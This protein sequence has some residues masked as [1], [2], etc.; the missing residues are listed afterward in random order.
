MSALKEEWASLLKLR[1]SGFT[2]E[3]KK[4]EIRSRIFNNFHSLRQENS[5]EVPEI[6]HIAIKPDYLSIRQQFLSTISSVERVK[7]PEIPKKFEFGLRNITPPPTHHKKNRIDLTSEEIWN[8]PDTPFTKNTSEIVPDKYE[9]NSI[10]ESNS[11]SR[12][13]SFQRKL[14]DI[15]SDISPITRYLANITLEEEQKYLKEAKKHDNSIFSYFHLVHCEKKN[16]SLERLEWEDMKLICNGLIFKSEILTRQLPQLSMEKATSI[17]TENPADG[18]S[19]CLSEP[20]MLLDTSIMKPSN[21][22][23]S[24]TTSPL[25]QATDDNSMLENDLLEMMDSIKNPQDS[26]DIEKKLKVLLEHTNKK[27]QNNKEISSNMHIRVLYQFLLEY[28][29]NNEDAKSIVKVPSVKR[30]A[31]TRPSQ[32]KTITPLRH[33]EVIKAA[34]TYSSMSSVKSSKWIGGGK[35]RAEFEDDD[36]VTISQE[37]KKKETRTDQLYKLSLKKK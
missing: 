33:K 30:V 25:L 12:T 32:K 8:I 37:K 5:R 27:L 21:L 9:V 36:W 19:K 29:K 18:I 1:E 16:L 28:M 20:P 14:L 34:D 22:K 11:F 31:Q 4:Q 15:F 23:S 17:L 10:A 35:H 3:T 24:S 26:L 2:D 13:Q 6:N 7:T